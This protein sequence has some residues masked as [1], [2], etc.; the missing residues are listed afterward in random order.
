MEYFKNECNHFN[1]NN[2]QKIH[3]G[4]TLWKDNGNTHLKL[5]GHIFI[6]RYFKCFELKFQQISTKIHF[7]LKVHFNQK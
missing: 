1:I 2:E 7:K 6:L 4:K 5:F 3:Y